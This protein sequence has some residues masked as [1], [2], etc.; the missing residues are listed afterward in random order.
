MG[1]N[2]KRREEIINLIKESLEK[3]LYDNISACFVYGSSLREDFNKLSDYDFLLILNKA[4][5]KTLTK[6]RR[7]RKNLINKLKVNIDINVQLDDEMPNS[8]GKLFWHNNRGFIVQIELQK[9]AKLLIGESPFKDTHINQIDIQ[10]EAIKVI[11]SFVYQ[12]RKIIISRDLNVLDRISI[13]KFCIYAT[14]YSLAFK[15]VFP[16]ERANSFNEFRKYFRTRCNP[17]LFFNL[18]K[19]RYKNI[20]NKDLALA[21]NFLLE[22]DHILFKEFIY[23]EAKHV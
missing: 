6:L 7:I 18:K 4:D 17:I 22:L 1:S 19:N 13:I 5:E 10:I 9:Y 15:N 8:R 11:D 2:I 16:E 20:T 23:K 14:Y 12:T 21:Y 3:N